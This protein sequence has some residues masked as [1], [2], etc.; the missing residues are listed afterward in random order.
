MQASTDSAGAESSTA[1]PPATTT[2]APTA[3]HRWSWRPRVSRGRGLPAA[4]AIDWQWKSIHPAV[5]LDVPRWIRMPGSHATAVQKPRD[6]RP[7]KMLTCHA[8]P[9]RQ[10]TGLCE[11]PLDGWARSPRSRGSQPRKAAT[12]KATPQARVVCQEPGTEW[13]SGAEIPEETAAATP[14]TVP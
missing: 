2:E 6:R 11:T 4:R 5:V 12:V 3:V 9:D 10:G 7:M 1:K 13:A 8:G 14:M